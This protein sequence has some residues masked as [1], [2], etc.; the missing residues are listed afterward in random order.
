MSKRS[1]CCLSGL[2][3]LAGVLVQCGPEG[4][5]TAA[6]DQGW[7]LAEN[8]LEYR[9][10]NPGRA[11]P[12][13]RWD[14]KVQVNYTIRLLSGEDLLSSPAGSPEV[15]IVG[16]WFSGFDKALHM[17]PPGAHYEFKVPVPLTRVG[18][19][20]GVYGIPP[21]KPLY[22]DLE[23]VDVTL[24]RRFRRLRPERTVDVGDGIQY[25]VLKEGH[26]E[27]PRAVDSVAYQLMHWSED[28][29]IIQC[30]YWNDDLRRTRVGREPVPGLRRILPLMKQNSLWLIKLPAGQNLAPGVKPPPQLHGDKASYMLVEIRRILRPLP[31]PE[32][33]LP[34]DDVLQRTA[35]GLRYQVVVAGDGERPKPG[36]SVRMHY[37]G[38]L[39]DGKLFDASYRK[40]RPATMALDDVIPGLREGLQLMQRGATYRFVI[41]AELAYGEEGMSPVIGANETLVFYVELRA[42]K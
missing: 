24:I 42:V 28:G 1:N 27:P 10:L 16:Q 15:R 3:L 39:T 32:F 40:G 33:V 38:W 22:L 25:E 19:R 6:G 20:G 11:E 4:D 23:L 2:A 31:V 41:P 36:Q 26:G 37:A 18:P 17:M 29:L 9:V 34:A 13:P 5:A 14:D 7:K 30:T 8:G 35:S 21:G 12:P